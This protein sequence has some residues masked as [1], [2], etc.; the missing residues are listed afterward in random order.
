MIVVVMNGG[1]GSSRPKDERMD[2][3]VQREL[4]HG[5]IVYVANNTFLGHRQARRVRKILK[6]TQRPEETCLLVGK[7][8]GG[9]TLIVKVLNQLPRLSFK[10]IHLLTVDPCFPKLWDWRPDRSQETLL[11]HEGRVDRAVN[12]LSAAGSRP[13][14][15]RV[16]GPPGIEVVT[17]EDHFSITT[18]PRVRREVGDLVHMLQG[19]E[20]LDMGDIL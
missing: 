7:S 18:C 14:G 6:L 12:L 3:V 4:P 1:S 9:Y 11:I 17:T 5:T 16:D 13:R 2:A 10:R 15:F 20:D 19:W 8:A